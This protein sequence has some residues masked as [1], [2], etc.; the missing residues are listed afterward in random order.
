MS[1]SMVVQLV[2]MMVKHLLVVALGFGG[3][4]KQLEVTSKD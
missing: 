2:L 1:A 3:Q 4:L